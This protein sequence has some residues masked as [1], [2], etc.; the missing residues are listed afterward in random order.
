[1]SPAP[2][3]CAEKERLLNEFMDAVYQCNLLQS[4]QTQALLTRGGEDTALE[5]QMDE[6]KEWRE[7]V[8]RALL[9]HQELHGC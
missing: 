4:I 3:V 8:K 6:A 1:M 9:F 7:R 2:Q 5:G